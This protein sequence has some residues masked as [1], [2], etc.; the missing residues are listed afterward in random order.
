MTVLVGVRCKDGVAIGA[1]SAATSGIGNFQLMKLAS[2][3]VS[4]IGDRTIVAGTGSVGLSQRFNG[5]V[6]AAWD[7]KAF[8][9]SRQ[10][11]LN[12]ITALAL[13]DFA[14]TNVQI[15]P[16]NGIGFGSL[17][18]CV[19]DGEAQLVEFA[20]A[21]LQPEVKTSQLNFVAMGS[22][23]ML[24][25]PFMGFVSRV[26]WGDRQPDVKTATFGVFW[27]LSHTLTIAPGGV[28]PPIKLAVL[29]R[30]KGTWSAKVLEH[31]ELDEAGQHIKAIE[32][33]I[34]RYPTE[35]FAEAKA[36][37]LPLGPKS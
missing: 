9:K 13:K 31:G 16:Q 26:L 22:G 1:D 12:E 14:S 36:S 19:L 24:A 35:I 23:Q 15:H 27:A 4:I 5:V 8:Q 21:D 33:R 32:E 10:I 3:K 17:M 28:G 34:G 18:A 2:D 30:D 6:K 20:T 29:S 37:P 25:E 11:C 7:N